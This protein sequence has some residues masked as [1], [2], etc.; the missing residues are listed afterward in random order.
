[1]GISTTPSFQQT[2][3]A[4]AQ[5]EVLSPRLL[6]CYGSAPPTESCHRGAG[7]AVVALALPSLQGDNVMP[8]G[9]VA[10]ATANQV[11]LIQHVWVRLSRKWKEVS[12]QSS[13]GILI[14]DKLG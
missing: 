1:M 5:V 14:S 3:A 6:R 12:N 2:A 4:A 7:V 9:L 11:W 8:P 10:V 13:M